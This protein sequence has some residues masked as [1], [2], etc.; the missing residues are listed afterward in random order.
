[1]ARGLSTGAIGILLT[2]MGEDGAAGRLAVRRAGEFTIAQDV[3]TAVEYGVSAA[4]RMGMDC[5]S[6]PL[7]VIALRVW[8]LVTCKVL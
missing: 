2:G 6:L 3:S 8:N 7:T 4:V 5:D 1:M